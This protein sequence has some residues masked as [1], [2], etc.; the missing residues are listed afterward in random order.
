MP[1][2]NMWPQMFEDGFKVFAVFLV[3]IVVPVTLLI[4]AVI[5]ISYFDQSFV[6]NN[7]PTMI[8]TMGINTVEYLTSGIMPAILSIFALTFNLFPQ[9]VFIL[10]RSKYVD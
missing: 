10:K 8:Q 9:L 4:L 2:Y 5:L 1:E 7:F 6:F 3:Y